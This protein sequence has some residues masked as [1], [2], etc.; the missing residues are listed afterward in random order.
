MA[1]GSPIQAGSGNAFTKAART[2]QSNPVCYPVIN[3]QDYMALNGVTDDG[4][5]L[6]AAIA[7][8]TAIH[9]TLV[10]PPFSVAR[11]ATPVPAILASGWRM[12]G[13]GG[14]DGNAPTILVDGNIT[15]LTLGVADGDPNGGTGPNRG[16][17]ERVSIDGM[18]FR[19]V[20]GG[21]A[22][23]GVDVTNAK[24]SNFRNCMVSG[25][26]SYGIWANGGGADRTFL[27]HFAE[28][29]FQSNQAGG[30]ALLKT[31]LVA[32]GTF[33]RCT[34]AGNTLSAAMFSLKLVGYIGI[35]IKKCDFEDTVTPGTNAAI[36][37]DWVGGSTFFGNHVESASWIQHSATSNVCVANTFQA[38]VL[39]SAGAVQYVYGNGLQQSMFLGN[40]MIAA[41]GTGFASTNAAGKNIFE[42][43][44]Y[45]G[46]GTPKNMAGVNVDRDL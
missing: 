34:F 6:A 39:T 22:H 24:N 14:D 38:N 28:C 5:A 46:L 18:A 26:S 19:G 20:N 44:V 25:F 13:L 8:T 29:D 12:K 17:I 45:G 11:V 3:A 43:N 2:Y 7:A 35:E 36:Y 21:A 1:L 23:H 4:P 32:G 33:Y 16:V 31:G 37:L 41:S 15:A 40:L 9:G 42:G 27:I 30:V 10:F